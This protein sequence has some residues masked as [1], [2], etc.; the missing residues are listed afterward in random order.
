MLQ[1]VFKRQKEKK[2]VTFMWRTQD[3][4]PTVLPSAKNILILTE[5]EDT[6]E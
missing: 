1:I 5:K 3:K 6:N 4:A 2:T